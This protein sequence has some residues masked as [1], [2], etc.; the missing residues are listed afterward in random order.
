VIT[1][2]DLFNDEEPLASAALDDF[3]NPSTVESHST[4][5]HWTRRRLESTYSGRSET[6][7]SSIIPTKRN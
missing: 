6:I 2:R 4:M 1:V 7:T 3:L 5:D